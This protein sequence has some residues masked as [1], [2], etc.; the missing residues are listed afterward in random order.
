MQSF[1][2]SYKS[3]SPGAF[4]PGLLVNLVKGL[5]FRAFWHLSSQGSERHYGLRIDIP[6]QVPVVSTGLY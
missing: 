5:P 4:A 3:K 2:S 1:F 6:F